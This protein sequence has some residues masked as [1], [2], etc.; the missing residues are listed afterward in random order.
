MSLIYMIRHGQASFGKDDYDKLSERGKAQA[1]ILGNYLHNL[2]V[3]CD[4]IITGSLK[5]HKETSMPYLQYSGKSD[6]PESITM[7]EFNEYDTKGV[8]TTLVPILLQEYPAMKRDV[9]A[10]F[11]SSQSFYRVLD[12]VMTMWS[13]GDYDRPNVETWK[14]FNERVNSGIDKIISNYSTEKV[15][16]IFTS[17]G[18]VSIA[19]KRALDLTDEGTMKIRDQVV[20]S[21][22]TRFKY[23]SDRFTL[24]SFNEYP[25]LEGH[26]NKDLITHY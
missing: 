23:S 7:T 1:E 9:D 15:I 12:A 4:V 19:V 8:F 22:F 13:S 11:I 6:V 16:G 2:N 25:H 26:N 10:I 3:G 21:S 14:E 20:N 24:T 5:R 18:P 17:G